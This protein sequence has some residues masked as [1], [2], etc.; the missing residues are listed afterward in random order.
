M[1]VEPRASSRRHRT[2]SPA[3]V[4]PESDLVI[5]APRSISRFFRF[6]C[7]ARSAGCRAGQTDRARPR[8][9][10]R[11]VPSVARE[12]F[13]DGLRRRASRPRGSRSPRPRRASTKASSRRRRRRRGRLIEVRSDRLARD[14]TR[15]HI[16]ALAAFAESGDQ[17]RLEGDRH[18]CFAL[19]DL[20]C[21][22]TFRHFGFTPVTPNVPRDSRYT[23]SLR[24]SQENYL[25]P[26]ETIRVK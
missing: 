15:R 13:R 14:C 5:G 23:V 25:N 24:H 16:V 19:A 7:P 2:T 6:A 11:D 10:G 17:L 18:P 9:L 22:G 4:T 20:F 1:R 3:G 21:F 8:R 26:I 12:A